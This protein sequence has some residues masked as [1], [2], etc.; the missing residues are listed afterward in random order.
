MT[1]DVDTRLQRSMLQDMVGAAERD[2]E[3]RRAR[4]S[5]AELEAQ[6]PA[7]DDPRPFREALTSPGLSV[8]AEFKRRSPSAGD[9]DSSIQISDQ[10]RI[11]QG[12]GAVALSILTDEEYFGGCLDDL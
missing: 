3:R 2:V 6:L 12:A 10:V 11:Y 1:T 7:R 4:V 5:L 8:I 9:I